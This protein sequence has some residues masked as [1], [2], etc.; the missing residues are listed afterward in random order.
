[1]KRSRRPGSNE[2][3]RGLENLIYVTLVAS[4]DIPPATIEEVGLFEENGGL[5]EAQPPSSLEE[6][7]AV[8]QKGE[9]RALSGLVTRLGAYSEQALEEIARAAREGGEI[10]EEIEE[11]MRLAREA[12]DRDRDSDGERK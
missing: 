11:R 8:L 5:G 3:E 6:P 9:E 7:L 4:G 1:M 2:N 10:P 12:V